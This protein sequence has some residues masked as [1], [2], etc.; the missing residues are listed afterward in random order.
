MDIS[1]VHQL[2]SALVDADLFCLVG[3]LLDKLKD[4]DGLI[5]NYVVDLCLHVQFGVKSLGTKRFAESA[6]LQDSSESHRNGKW[7]ELACNFLAE[8]GRLV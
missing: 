4:I 7:S 3:K 1:K 2:G 5:T 8:L 6:C